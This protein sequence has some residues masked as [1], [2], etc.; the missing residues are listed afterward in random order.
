MVQILQGAP[1]LHGNDAATVKGRAAR[2]GERLDLLGVAATDFG[3]E[4][5]AHA[6]PPRQVADLREVLRPS[7]D[8][9]DH[10]PQ[11]TLALHRRDGD[12]G[13]ILTRARAELPIDGAPP[14]EI[15]RAHV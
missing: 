3:G 12:A 8:R 5:A 14:A 15:G 10:D 9:A 1:D 6:L 4:L 13:P 11:A 2:V 7:G